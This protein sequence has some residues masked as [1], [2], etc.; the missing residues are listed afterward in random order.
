V[1]FVFTHVV[2]FPPFGPGAPDQP[3][4]SL[5]TRQISA[6]GWQPEGCWQTLKPFWPPVGPQAREQHDC[7]HCTEPDGQTVPATLQVPTPFPPGSPQVPFGF[8]PTL[9]QLPEQHWS[10]VKQT[11]PFWV[12][13]ETSFEQA[14]FVHR[15][16]QHWVAVVHPLPAVRQPPPG[17]TGAHKPLVQMPLQQSVPRVQAP[18]VGLSGTQA[19]VAHWRFEPQKPEQQSAPEVHAPPVFL[20]APPPDVLQTFGVVAPQTPPLGHAPDP[21]PHAS[22][23][24][25]PS[26]MNPQLMP[27]QAV[28]WAIG[29]HWLLPPHWLDTPPPPQV[30]GEAHC[31][32]WMTSPQ[33]FAIG[34]QAFGGQVVTVG[35][36]PVSP[37]PPQTFA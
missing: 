8:V 10:F 13:K 18:G 1:T 32:H 22:R 37:P 5:S 35:V 27:A 24:P 12:Q 26:G 4:Q 14:P 15:F 33:P 23:P 20:Q 28:A 19:L 34:P 11:S 17:L 31:P 2:G 29:V 16:E 25:Q 36:Q 9:A 3:Q 7:S 30:A 6:I 21:T